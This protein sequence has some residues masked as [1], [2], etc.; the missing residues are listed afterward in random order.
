MKTKINLQSSCSDR[1]SN[2]TCP[3]TLSCYSVTRRITLVVT[4]R[5]SHTGCH[6]SINCTE[7]F[8]EKGIKT[9]YVV[10]STLAYISLVHS[11]ELACLMVSKLFSIECVILYSSS[12]FVPRLYIS[13][14]LAL[15][16][17]YWIFRQDVFCV[18]IISFF[19]VLVYLVCLRCGIEC[20]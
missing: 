6:T 12:A 1:S 9:F 17:C 3:Y 8:G 15:F 16:T 14:C 18:Y 2:V 10:W 13:H 11:L 4:H 5:L 19:W 7:I 20:W